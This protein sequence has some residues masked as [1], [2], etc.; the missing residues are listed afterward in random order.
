MDKSILN[1]RGVGLKFSFL[2]NLKWKILF[3]NSEY[4]D[5]MPHQAAADLGLHIVPMPGLYEFI[6]TYWVFFNFLKDKVYF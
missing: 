6:N 5:Q 1:S 4:P 2:F 3:A